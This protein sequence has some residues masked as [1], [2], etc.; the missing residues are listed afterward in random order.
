MPAEFNQILSMTLYMLWIS[1][2]KSD[3]VGDSAKIFLHIFECTN[4][5]LKDLH[6]FW[7]PF[8]TGIY[9]TKFSCELSKGKQEI[10]F[11]LSCL[12]I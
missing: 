7:S 11:R 8:S 3:E 5:S 10:T 12:N 6:F 9:A 4:N 1:A 2:R